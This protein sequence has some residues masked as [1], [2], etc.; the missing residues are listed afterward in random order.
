MNNKTQQETE[1]KNLYIDP[2]QLRNLIREYKENLAKNPDAQM[3]NDL[4]I[5]L[6]NLAK[7]FASRSCFSSYSYRADFE[8]C[9]VEKMI[10][11]VEK[12]DPDD[13]RSPFAYLTQTCYRA[14]INYIKKE[15]KYVRAKDHIADYV[16]N[17]FARKEGIRE[18][19]NQNYVD[20]DIVPPKE[21]EQS[22]DDV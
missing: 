10:K 1:D 11:A 16:Y 13:K 22:I 3:S 8:A 21:S 20:D 17:E 5:C 14:I 12:I 18:Q 6:M 7:R 2:Q 19:H 4:G 15:N 9:A